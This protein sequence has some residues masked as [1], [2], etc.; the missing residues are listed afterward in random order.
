MKRMTN[1]TLYLLLFAL[2]LTSCS[3]KKNSESL[4]E[5]KTEREQISVSSKLAGKIQKINATEGEMVQAGDTLL[6]L[7]LPEVQ[8]KKE[9]AKG[10]LNSAEAQYNMAKKGATAGQLTQLNA[11]VSASKEQMDFAEKSMFRLKNMLKDSLISQ[12]KFDEVFTKYQGAKNQY[13]AAEAELTEA[14]NGARLEQQQMALGQQ[15]R[16]VGA[17]NEVG[18]A[19]K[20]RFIIAPQKMSIESISLKQGELALPGY[21]LV[22]GF[23]NNTTFFRF[24]TTEKQAAKMK[25]G[26]EV[27]VQAINENKTIKGKIVWIKPLSA[28]AN[29]SSAYPDYEQGQSLFEIKVVP[30]NPQEASTLLLKGTVHL[31]LANTNK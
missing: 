1:S 23:L 18:V 12:Q 6:V 13:I 30:L 10:A 15:E 29:I 16:A 7:E 21:S 14:K 20:E 3:T 27:S 26:Q 25:T 28:Y 22:S 9:Q 2:L 19:E 4:L 11:K 5:G 24:T 31:D 8:A 17:L